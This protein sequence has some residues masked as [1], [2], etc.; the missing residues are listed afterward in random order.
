MKICNKCKG[1]SEDFKNF[2]I[3]GS[4]QVCGRNDFENKII[5]LCQECFFESY[6]H[7]TG[8]DYFSECEE[9]K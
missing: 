1:K 8:K 9:G 2:G 5:D 6:H 7:M 4:F 3:Y